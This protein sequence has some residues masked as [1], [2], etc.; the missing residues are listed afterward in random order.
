MNDDIIEHP[1]SRKPAA[2]LDQQAGL[3][4]SGR[5]VGTCG[6]RGQET[7]VQGSAEAFRAPVSHSSPAMVLCAWQCDGRDSF[8]A[9]AVDACMLPFAFASLRSSLRYQGGRIN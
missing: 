2:D 5:Q 9:N 7:T 1:D 4:V 3:S 8:H 6:T